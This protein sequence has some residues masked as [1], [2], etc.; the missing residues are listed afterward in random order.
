M[1][2]F[3]LVILKFSIFL[4]VN[5]KIEIIHFHSA[6]NGSFYRKS[7]L[8]IIAKFIFS[9][10]CVFQIHGGHFYAF[11]KKRKW[12]GAYVSFVFSKLDG[13]IFLVK[14]QRSQF[15]EELSLNNTY[16]INNIIDFR[17]Y[18][19]QKENTTIKL[20]F[21][22]KI[23]PAKGIFDLVDSVKENKDYL[24]G[25]IQIIVGG[26][27]DDIKL[28]DLIKTNGLENIILFRGWLKGSSKVN[29]YKESDII[30][31]PSYTEAMPMSI[32]EGMSYSMPVIA[33]PVGSIPEFVQNNQNGILIQIKNKKAILEAI[34]YYI[35]NSDKIIDHGKKSY[36]I[37]KNYFPDIF[38]QKIS[39]IYMDL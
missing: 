8:F 12:I 17:E 7:I 23:T 5:K 36:E 28:K 32:L 37:S 13:I 4:L 11:F 16:L 30:I 6:S 26:S 29:A 25:K 9:K 19:A 10:K 18:E 33:T 24:L 22:G 34:D 15:I 3:P 20:L 14:E 38:M 31:L 39:N 27:G 35:K 1:L 21:L 2:L